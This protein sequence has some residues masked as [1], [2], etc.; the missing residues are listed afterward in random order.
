MPKL[1]LFIVCIILIRCEDNPVDSKIVQIEVRYFHP[2]KQYVNGYEIFSAVASIS[3]DGG[4][5]SVANANQ[6]IEISVPDGASLTAM[7]AS[8]FYSYRGRAYDRTRN[9]E[10]NFT[11]S[12]G[13]LWRF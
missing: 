10:L 1:L 9:Y 6:Y 2:D 3:W 11:A 12:S 7:F 13:A 8:N 5:T 4:N